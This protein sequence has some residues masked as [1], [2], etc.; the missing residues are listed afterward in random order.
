MPHWLKISINFLPPVYDGFDT[1]QV[2][3]FFTPVEKENQKIMGHNMLHIECTLLFGTKKG[4]SYYSNIPTKPY[5]R[6]TGSNA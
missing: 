1:N 4:K 6:R 2:I 3:D 5:G